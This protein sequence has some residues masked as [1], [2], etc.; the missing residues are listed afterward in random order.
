[1]E[2][3]KQKSIAIDR[4]VTD[5]FGVYGL[6]G[7]FFAKTFSKK[8][9]MLEKIQKSGFTFQLDDDGFTRFTY[10]QTY[11]KNQNES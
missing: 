11:L 7:L 2:F 5:F 10:R 3:L 4:A 1:M 6:Y 8:I 9:L